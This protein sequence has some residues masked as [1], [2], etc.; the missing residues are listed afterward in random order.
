MA[1]L[2]KR[3][4][5]WQVRI[6]RT[7]FPTQTQS[8]QNKSDALH[9]ARTQELLRDQQQAPAP[10]LTNPFSDI[11]Q[12]YRNEVSIRKRGYASEYY[13]IQTLLRAPELQRQTGKITSRILY[14]YRDRRLTEVSGCTVRKELYLLSAIF[15]HLHTE[16]SDMPIQNPV[17]G[18]HKPPNAPQRIVRL[19]Q[20]Q[21]Q[22]LQSHLTSYPDRLLAQI[23]EVALETGL[24]RGDLLSLTPAQIHVDTQLLYLATSKN[25]YGRCIP[26][27]KR[28]FAILSACDPAQKQIF[29]LKYLYCRL[30]SIYVIYIYRIREKENI[31]Y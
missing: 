26:L 16:W 17:Q 4:Q 19:S 31:N 22:T 25:G 10:I 14:Q 2:N 23:V 20:S 28:A 12:R 24:R 8:F 5:T 27:S 6:L 11:L 21:R 30:I 18:M 13:R 9:W 1:T 3:N 29:I 15:C 7:G